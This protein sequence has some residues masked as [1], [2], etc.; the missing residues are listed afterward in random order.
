MNQK[1]AHVKNDCIVHFSVPQYKNLSLEKI[2]E[3]ISDYPVAAEY[4]PD[5]I[6]LPKTPK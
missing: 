1:K 6:D 4:L 3:F 2:M 5:D